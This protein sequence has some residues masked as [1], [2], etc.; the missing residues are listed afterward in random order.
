MN[1][2][3]T[4]LSA[5][6][7]AST[8]PRLSAAISRAVTSDVWARQHETSSPVARSQMRILKSSPA[9]KSLEPSDE[10]ASALTLSR[11]PSSRVVSLARNS[12]PGGPM[13]QQ[14]MRLSNAPE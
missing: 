14:Q 13:S 7:D 1:H 11:E 8:A 5:D 12:R 4:V 6:A 3:L 10:I 2:S 9:E